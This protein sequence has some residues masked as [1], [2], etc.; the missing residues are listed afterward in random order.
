MSLEYLHISGQPEAVKKSMICVF[1]S[2]VLSSVPKV[3]G[4]F[5]FILKKTF[6][7]CVH[8]TFFFMCFVISLRMN[9][10]DIPRSL[11][12]LCYSQF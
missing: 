9:T 3:F 1:C 6:K 7:I 8:S 10:F 4:E 12:S 5:F 2:N 11:L